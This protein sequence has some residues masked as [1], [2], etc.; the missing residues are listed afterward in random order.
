M[1]HLTKIFVVIALIIFI[2]GVILQFI[3][4]EGAAIKLFVATILFMICA[5]ISRN[6]DR[7]KQQ[8]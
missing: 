7:K 6:N 4:Q 8:K 3:N 5:F 2:L 1:K